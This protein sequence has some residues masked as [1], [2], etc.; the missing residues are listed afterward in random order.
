MFLASK[1]LVALTRFLQQKPGVWLIQLLLVE[2]WKDRLEFWQFVQA[3]EKCMSDESL[4]ITDRYA[5]AAI[6]FAIFSR[7][8]ASDL[9]K[10][11]RWT[12][13][14]LAN[15]GYLECGTR[16]HKSKRLVA[17]QGILMP[18]VAPIWGVGDSAWGVKFLDIA[19]QAK[20]PLAHG[21]EG[22]LLPAPQEAGTWSQR[23]VTSTELTSW[24]RRLLNIYI[25]DSVSTD[26]PTSHSLKATHNSQLVRKVWIEIRSQ[27]GFGPSLHRK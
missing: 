12:V 14:L 7:S 13:D 25:P 22:P 3:L 23:S 2:R 9:V 20:I 5:A 4:S 19:R 11:E 17:K 6:V 26:M 1:Q 24:L 27:T 21:Y 10:I 16:N 8:R 15:S 18:L